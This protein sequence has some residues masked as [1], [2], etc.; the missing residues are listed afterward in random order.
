MPG[1]YEEL[2]LVIIITQVATVKLFCSVRH[3]FISVYFE[4]KDFC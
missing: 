2:M 1:T 4:E 3:C